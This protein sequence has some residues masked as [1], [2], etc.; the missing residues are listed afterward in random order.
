[1][2][3]RQKLNSQRDSDDEK[4]RPKWERNGPKEEERVKLPS[5]TRENSQ[6]T[7][8]PEQGHVFFRNNKI[9]PLKGEAHQAIYGSKHASTTR[10]NKKSL[11]REQNPAQITDSKTPRVPLTQE[12]VFDM[13]LVKQLRRA[14]SKENKQ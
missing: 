10:H 8:Q 14:T 3:P 13:M 2:S 7:F 6:E 5:L 11:E 9:I 1:M 4:R 12:N